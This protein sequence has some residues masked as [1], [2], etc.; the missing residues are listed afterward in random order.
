MFITQSR[1]D[2]ESHHQ[3]SN[4]VAQQESL[5]LFKVSAEGQVQ[6]SVQL[7]QTRVSLSAEAR[8]L[9][10][11]I[12]RGD[13][14]VEEEFSALESRSEQQS[15]GLSIRTNPVVGYVPLTDGDTETVSLD[16]RTLM[17]KGIIEAM[18]G[19]SIDLYDP[20]TA[21]RGGEEPKSS[22]TLEVV[23]GEENVDQQGPSRVGLRYQYTELRHEQ[24]HTSFSAEGQVQTADG[25]TISIDLELNMS[26]SFVEHNHLEIE[27]G[28]RLKDPLV[29]NFDGRAA[30]LTQQK[31][32]F[33]IDAD[34]SADQV[35][36]VGE[37][38]GLLAL[39][40]NN[41]GEINDGT[42]LFGALS[43][44]GFAD[45]LEY[46]EDGNG[47]ID[48]GDA[49]YDSLRIWVKTPDGSDQLLALGDRNVGAIYLGSVETPFDLKDSENELQGRIRASGV[50]I[51]EEGGSGTVQQIDLV[52]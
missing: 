5:L 50:Y 18:I 12:E 16:A 36:F 35:S 10:Q 45:L 40:R 9:A 29:I 4:S 43:G 11:R 7:D 13:G 1:L 48:E 6:E 31:Y 39:D 49:I 24:E 25:R 34:G 30:E 52:V 47:F 20:A 33:D 23:A 38:S 26:R 8:S 17:I 19:K 42:E 32:Q 41:D 15:E 2:L 22:S 21:M 51:G 44:N 3:A 28:A 27:A 14:R 46:D 37:H